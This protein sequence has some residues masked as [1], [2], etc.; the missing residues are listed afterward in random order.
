MT[1]K[2]GRK[3]SQREENVYSIQKERRKRVKD[4]KKEMRKE[5]KI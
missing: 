5:T 4:R 3:M 2:E 1:R